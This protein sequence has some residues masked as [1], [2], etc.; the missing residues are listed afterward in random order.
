MVVGIGA[1][2]YNLNTKC[3]GVSADLREDMM[4]ARYTETRYGSAMSEMRF[5]SDFKR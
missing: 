3:V 1:E 5:G 4:M 2:F